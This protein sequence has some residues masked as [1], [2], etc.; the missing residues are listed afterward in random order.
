MVKGIHISTFKCFYAEVTIIKVFME[1]RRGFELVPDDIPINPKL[2][3]YLNN[4]IKFY[5]WYSFDQPK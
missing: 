4:S 2:N 1:L 3:L 5:I